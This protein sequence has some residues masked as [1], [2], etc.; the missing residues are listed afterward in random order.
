MGDQ[1]NDRSYF[2]KALE[3]LDRDIVW[4]QER[5]SKIQSKVML[6]IDREKNK[7]RLFN[8]FKYMSSIGVMIALLLFGY[9]FLSDSM[10]YN[11]GDGTANTPGNQTNNSL[12]TGEADNHEEKN[13][14]KNENKEI[15]KLNKSQVTEEE[16]LKELDLRLPAHI[17]S[18]ASNSP[19]FIKLVHPDGNVTAEVKYVE[20]K[21]L[22]FNYV[23]EEIN[24]D[25]ETVTEKIK[26]V[27]YKD[28]KLEEIEINGFPSYLLLEGDTSS[29]YS[30]LHIVIDNHFFTIT[31]HGIG[32]DEIIKIADSI[33][34]T[35]L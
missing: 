19:Q 24:E 1:F 5:K 9:N 34:F 18:E 7:S 35:G 21:E 28:E 4:N 25:T 10:I 32:K 27:M 31:T 6:T 17:P 33:D 8:S 22:F 14:N 13:E 2:D 12:I 16:L 26:N 11:N 29:Y 23:Q 30:S 20:T 15:P 3:Q